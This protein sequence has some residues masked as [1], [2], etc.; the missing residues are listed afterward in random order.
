MKIALIITSLGMGGAER[1]VLDLADSL[2]AEGHEVLVAFLTG[3]AVLSPK[4]PRVRVVPLRLNSVFSL[5]PA[6]LRLQHVLRSFRPDVVHSHM[7]HANI[8]SR[9]TRLFTKFPR[10]IC[11]AHC[12]NEG[13]YMRMLAYRLTDGLADIST[14]VSDEAVRA[15]IDLGAVKAGRMITVHNGIREE[16]FLFS[17]ANR[18]SSRAELGVAPDTAMILAIGR[19]YLQKDYPNLLRAIKLIDGVRRKYVVYVVGTGPL[20]AEL[21]KM[22][23]ELGVTDI[24]TFLGLRRDVPK[25]MSAAD[26]FVLSSSYEGFPL[27][28][29]EAMACERVIVA[30]DCGGVSEFI[31]SSGFLV[32]PR[33]PIALAA[34]LSTAIALSSEESSHLGGMARERVVSLFSH[35]RAVARWLSLYTTPSPMEVLPMSET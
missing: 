10:L 26:I 9:L 3:P 18:I 25:L 35:R 32:A 24:V 19:L 1:V 13:G 20:R 33:D 29:G 14:N 17:A 23:S 22:V 21:M 12:K 11:T 7:V 27:V 28:I 2:T 31:G 34:G 30:T 4:S 6:F 8:L 5:I 16:E 15:F